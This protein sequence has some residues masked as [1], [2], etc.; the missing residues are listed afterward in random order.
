MPKPASIAVHVWPNAPMVL[1]PLKRWRHHLLAGLMSGRPLTTAQCEA[2]PRRYPPEVLP[3]DRARDGATSPA[4][5]GESSILRDNPPDRQGIMVWAGVGEE[6]VGRAG[7]AVRARRTRDGRKE[8]WV[9]VDPGWWRG[10]VAGLDV[11]VIIDPI[12]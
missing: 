8:G 12:D 3:D 4:L 2:G 5:S 6:V 11:W 10:G 9:G 1:F 7:G